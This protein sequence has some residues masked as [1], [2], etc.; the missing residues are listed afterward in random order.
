MTWSNSPQVFIKLYD[1]ALTEEENL[2]LIAFYCYRF[3]AITEDFIHSTHC[4]IIPLYYETYNFKFEDLY[5]FEDREWP[6]GINPFS[7]T[8]V[9]DI[10]VALYQ[11]E[12]PVSKAIE[13]FDQNMAEIKPE[14]P[15][16]ISNH[17]KDYWWV[18]D[19]KKEEERDGAADVDSK[20]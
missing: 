12:T 1:E 4:N 18:Y 16:G 10:L 6:I 13:M 15:E 19:S 2:F 20:V 9:D 5:D 3:W 17:M 11:L 14:L 7:N 8:A